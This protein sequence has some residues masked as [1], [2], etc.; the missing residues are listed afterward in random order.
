MSTAE[1]IH[2]VAEP[3]ASPVI[4]IVPPSDIHA[5]MLASIGRTM[6]IG[7]VRIPLLPYQVL[8]QGNK[9]VINRVGDRA[10]KLTVVGPDAVIFDSQPT[11]VLQNKYIAQT[12]GLFIS[13]RRIIQSS[14]LIDCGVYPEGRSVQSQR[15]AVSDSITR[16]INLISDREGDSLITTSGQRG[17]R[18]SGITDVLVTDLRHTPDYFRERQLATEPFF[19]DYILNNG[20]RPAMNEEGFVYAARAAMRKVATD[21]FGTDAQQRERFKTISRQVA[22]ISDSRTNLRISE[23]YDEWSSLEKRSLRDELSNSLEP[24]WQSRASCRGPQRVLF[25]PRSGYELKMEKQ[26]RL[27]QAKKICASCPVQP[28]CLKESVLNREPDGVWGG[29]D[30]DERRVLIKNSRALDLKIYC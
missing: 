26:Q 19:E 7:S 5:E 12:L 17:G 27:S 25:Y 29:F 28:E 30:E 22:S 2:R 8:H 21:S 18:R 3:D 14:E 9:Q 11:V 15:S 23:I 10:R 4:E 1:V 24:S 20:P 6:L 13:G 16:L